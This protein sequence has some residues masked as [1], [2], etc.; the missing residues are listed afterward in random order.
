MGNTQPL[1][2]LKTQREN[3]E[4]KEQIISPTKTDQET[5]PRDIIIQNPD[6]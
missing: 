5:I 6:A 1:F 4:T 2:F 3:R